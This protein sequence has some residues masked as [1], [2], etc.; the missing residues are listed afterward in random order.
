[1]SAACLAVTMGASWIGCGARAAG[2]PRSQLSFDLIQSRV[3][4]KTEAEVERI[5]GMPD[6]REARL[7]DDDVWIW[8]DY[9][10]LDGERYAPE[11]RGQIVHLEITFDKPPG[12]AGQDLPKAAWRVAGPFSVNFSRRAPK[13]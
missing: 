7:V 11:V 13:S 2:P 10:Y 4:G 5:L 8:W 9:T 12:L 1:M 3:V 6:T